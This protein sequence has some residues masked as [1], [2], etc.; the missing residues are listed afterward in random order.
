MNRPFLLLKKSKRSEIEQSHRQI[1]L[2][3]TLYGRNSV[4]EIR[5]LQ[6]ALEE[7]I[8]VGQAHRL[9]VFDELKKKED[10]ASGLA[11][12]MKFSDRITGVLLEAL[13]ELK[14]LTKKDEIYS[15]TGE[16]ESR[17]VDRKGAGYEGDFWQFL[18][19]LVDPWR[20]LEHV[21]QEGEPDMAS[22][23]NF[24][25]EDFIRGMDSPW[26]K[27]LAPEIVDI[28]LSYLDSP[29][30]VADIGGAPG[31][32]ARE[33]A[34]RGC[35]TVVFD[36]ADCLEVTR[37]ELSAVENIT[38]IDGDATESLP[39][40]K[41]D[42]AFLGNICHGQSPEDNQKIISM[43]HEA[44]NPGGIVVVFE[45]IRGYSYLGARLALH[46]IT[47]SSLGDI[48]TLEEYTGWLTKAGFP[49]PEMK[50]LSEKA[51]HLLIS[52]KQA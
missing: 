32:M 7:F 33:F 17:L 21:L 46:M 9:G 31:T 16:T 45:N 13:V 26:K 29:G 10:S 22:Y 40:K 14:Y 24:S 27:R 44:L 28:C 37:D 18:Y 3:G 49:E 8:F 19:Y 36:L 4:M 25:F 50:P 51:W 2:P 12:R 30:A 43:C 47:Q 1:F 15:I 23:E 41:I 42:V 52:Q 20:T 5:K 35:E 39:K 38:V 11:E 34:S 6:E 48:Y